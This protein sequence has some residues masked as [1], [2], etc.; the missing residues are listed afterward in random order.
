MVSALYELPFGKGKRWQPGNS[1]ANKMVSGWQV[2]TIGTMQTGKPLAITGANNF[3]ANRPNSTGRSPKLEHPTPTKWFDTEQFVNPPNFT[4]GNVG[5]VLPDVRE[6]GITNWDLSL[7]KNT[8]LTERVA[9]Q[10][11]AEAFNFLNHVNL[12]RPS[13]GFSPGPDGRNQSGSFG[14][15]TSSREARIAQFAL[16]LIF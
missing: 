14:V 1:V 6:P 2:N 7:I 5:T 16:K 15:I 11:R 9:L 8:L 3:R 10:F 12:G 13:T 4:V